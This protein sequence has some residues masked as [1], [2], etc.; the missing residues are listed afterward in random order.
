M[1]IGIDKGTTFTKDSNQ[2]I[3]QST[4]REIS[5]EILLERNLIVEFEGKKYVVGEKGN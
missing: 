1:V 3:I 5:D 2:N 4:I